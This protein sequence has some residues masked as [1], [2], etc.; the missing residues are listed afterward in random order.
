M[1]QNFSQLIMFLGMANRTFHVS[2]PYKM[3][4]LSIVM[5]IL[6]VALAGRTHSMSLL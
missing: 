1:S 2:R 5:T 3:T 6:R 4:I